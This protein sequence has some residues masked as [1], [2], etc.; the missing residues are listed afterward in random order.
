MKKNIS[1]ILIL[2]LTVF[3]GFTKKEKPYILL[4]SG[5]NAIYGQ[6][7]RNERYF[8]T[9]QRIF[10]NLVIPHGVKYQGVRM[11]LSKQDDKTSNWGFSI[12]LA[13]DLY[14]SQT[15]TSYKDYLK[16]NQKGHYILQFFYLNNKR[17]PFAHIEFMVN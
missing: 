10:Y 14:L 3:C 1:I 9:G 12:I 4:S 7:I 15:E 8:E 6:T 13:K 2:C 5:N 17:Y 16:I 11:Q